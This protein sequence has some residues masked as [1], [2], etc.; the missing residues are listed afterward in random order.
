[1]FRQLNKLTNHG[2]CLSNWLWMQG[3]CSVFAVLKKSLSQLGF[4]A[5]SVRVLSFCCSRSCNCFWDREHLFLGQVTQCPAGSTRACR[6]SPQEFLGASSTGC[7]QLQWTAMLTPLITNLHH[8]HLEMVYFSTLFPVCF[9]AFRLSCVA[10]SA[11][12]L[13]GTWLW[14]GTWARLVFA[15]PVQQSCV[16]SWWFCG[17]FIFLA[18]S[19]GSI[20]FSVL[21]KW[22]CI[23]EN[24]SQINGLT[25]KSL[26]MDGIWESWNKKKNNYSVF[27]QLL[28]SDFGL[29][30]PSW[31]IT[32][33]GRP[34]QCMCEPECLQSEFCHLL[35]FSQSTKV[36]SVTDWEPKHI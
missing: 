3:N 25:Y 20:C 36:G 18:V 24:S 12:Q 7:A 10:P 9:S 19:S 22:I 32:E 26:L 17:Y 34:R 14:S 27:L 11:A 23:K 15:H 28:S 8:M 33:Q 21:V 16:V 5:L 1:M 35:I 29:V 30:C 13:S 4:R 6:T 31:D 2:K